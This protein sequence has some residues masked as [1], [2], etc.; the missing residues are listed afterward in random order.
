[1]CWCGRGLGEEASKAPEDDDG[2]ELLELIVSTV[3]YYLL[4]YDKRS[5]L[6]WL[7]LVNTVVGSNGR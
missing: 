2:P 6:V 5:Q 4:Y 1:L 7:L 3:D